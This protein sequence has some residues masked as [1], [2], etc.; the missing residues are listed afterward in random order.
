MSIMEYLNSWNMFFYVMWLSMAVSLGLC[1]GYEI[2]KWG[3]KVIDSLCGLSFK[4][5]K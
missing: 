5:E 3:N 1:F 2:F 4:K